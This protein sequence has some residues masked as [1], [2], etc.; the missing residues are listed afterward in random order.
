[1]FVRPSGL[2]LG[3]LVAVSGWGGRVRDLG[4]EVGCRSFRDAVDKNAQEG[5]PKEYVE[6]DTEAEE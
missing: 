2:A 5:D 6:A 1:M 3:E 4:D